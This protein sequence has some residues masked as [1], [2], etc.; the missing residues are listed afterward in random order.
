VAGAVDSLLEIFDWIGI[1]F[2]EGPRSGGPQAPYI[3]SQ[4]LDLYR[5]HAEDLVVGGGAY[6]CWCSTERLAKVRDEQAARHEPPRYDRVCRDLSREEIEARLKTDAPYVIRQ[7]LPVTGEVKVFDEL[8]GEIIFAAADLDD[9]VLLKS[10]G[11]PTYQLA[12]VVDD[13]LMAISHVT[14]G[15]EWLPSLPKN[16]LLYQAFGWTPPKFIHLPLILNRGGGKLSKRQG[17]VFVE[18]Y[19]AKGYLPEALINFCALLGWHGKSDREIFS[20]SE[21]EKIFDLDGLGASAAVF[22]Q[23][24]LDWFNG[25][26]IRQKSA[27]ELV[28]LC[29]PYLGEKTS[30]EEYL[31][32]VAMLEQPRLKKLSDIAAAT[33]FF[34]QAPKYDADLLIWKK[35]S[36][37]AVKNNLETLRQKLATLKAWQR[38]EREI[39]DWLETEKLSK[40][41]YLWPL[42][43]ALTGRQMSPGPF[44][45]ALVLGREES[46]KRIKTAIEKL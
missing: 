1:G 36:A 5:R 6:R 8:R 45:V 46:L 16:V 23:E 15:E 39:L 21:L 22:D 31:R 20:L 26:Y 9:Q 12:S 2:D 42:R 30:D 43:A 35:L 10:D 7:R 28:D 4:R 11:R 3:Q 29:R 32:Q 13:H 24:K 27:T 37:A 44:E 25:H 17:D 33:D 41:D 38:V 34:F 19:R 14:R 18:D 40:G